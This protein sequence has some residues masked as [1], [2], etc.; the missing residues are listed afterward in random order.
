[1][2]IILSLLLSFLYLNQTREKSFF[3]LG[4]IFRQLSSPSTVLF[5]L[6]Q[7]SM[8][9]G[10]VIFSSGCALTYFTIE[11]VGERYM[12]IIVYF[13]TMKNCLFKLLYIKFFTRKIHL[14]YFE[15]FPFS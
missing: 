15:S 2:L 10:S 6:F 11:K 4:D 9:I 13:I 5:Y 8:V 14:L 3:I 12:N 7:A 1:M